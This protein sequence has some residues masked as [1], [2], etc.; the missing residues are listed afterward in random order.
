MSFVNVIYGDAPVVPLLSA[1]K[2]IAII[3]K[4]TNFS[5]LIDN[6]GSAAQLTNDYA[7]QILETDS[8]YI[9]TRDFIARN[10]NAAS[11][12]CYALADS[13]SQVTDVEFVGPKNGVNG[14]FYVPYS[15]ADSYTN[16]E[17]YV[18]ETL[19]SESGTEYTAG[20]YDVIG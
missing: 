9:A 12:I 7:G 1:P 20:W 11:V 8:L 5:G 6:V 3:G 16:L 4:A 10:G 14:T 15:P 13:A 18:N 17:I 19:T 2:K